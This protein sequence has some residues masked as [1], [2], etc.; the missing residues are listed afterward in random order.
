MPQLIRLSIQLLLNVRL[1][2]KAWEQSTRFSTY[3]HSYIQDDAYHNNHT[4]IPPI[5]AE[6]IIA[7]GVSK[8]TCR[9]WYHT[10]HVWNRDL[11]FH[12]L[13]CQS[14]TRQAGGV[15]FRILGF[16]VGSNQHILI[17]W[18]EDAEKCMDLGLVWGN[19]PN[20][21]I[22]SYLSC[23]LLRGPCVQ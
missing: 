1:W 4:I 6:S 15:I 5:A 20:P 19:T 13:L 14:S 23:C 9:I 2:T 12:E 7:E 17:Y 21:D 18:Q 22:S 8:I 10:L 11:S 16:T 3:L